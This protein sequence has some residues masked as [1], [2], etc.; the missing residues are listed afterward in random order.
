MQMT[1]SNH[2]T[3]VTSPYWVAKR[4]WTVEQA[5]SRASFHPEAVKWV[6]ALKRKN[7]QPSSTN[8]ICKEHLISASPLPCIT[9]IAAGRKHHHMTGWKCIFQEVV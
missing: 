7:W 6:E 1:F 2:V 5:T 4:Y 3:F 9:E 8:Q